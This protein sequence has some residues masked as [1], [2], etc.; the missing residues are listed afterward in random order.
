[1]FL[2]LPTP[3]AET[4]PRELGPPFTPRKAYDRFS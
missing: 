3:T 2:T 4:L 1:M